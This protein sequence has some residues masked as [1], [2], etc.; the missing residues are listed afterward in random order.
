[1]SF[2]ICSEISDLSANHYFIHFYGKTHMRATA[3]VFGILVGFLVHVM[4]Q[5]DMKL[6]RPIVY[7]CWTTATIVGSMSMF[8]L[9]FFYHSDIHFTILENS[10]YAGLHRLGW[11][12]ATGWI[13]LACVCGYGGNN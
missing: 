3:Y 9:T 5:R 13:V 6:S 11:S 4:Q 12:L 8:S 2:S 7:V 1:M 10:I